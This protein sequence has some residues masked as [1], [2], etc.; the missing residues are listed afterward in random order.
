MVTYAFLKTKFARVHWAFPIFHLP[1]YHKQ[2]D[3]I[4]SVVGEQ[5]KGAFTSILRLCKAL[6]GAWRMDYGGDHVGECCI[7][8]YKNHP[9]CAGHG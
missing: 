5:R 8:V 1:E 3:I 6:S 9:H 4:A 7:W 2:M